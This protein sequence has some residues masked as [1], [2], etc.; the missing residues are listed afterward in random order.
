MVKPGTCTLIF[1]PGLVALSVGRDCRSRDCELVSKPD[2][3]TL[4]GIDHEIISKAILPL[5]QVQEVQ[6]SVT[7]ERMCTKCWLYCY[8]SLSLPLNSV[9]LTD[10]LNITLI[11]LTVLLN[12][13]QTNQS[14]QKNMNKKL[15]DLKKLSP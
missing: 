10:Q 4:V 1:M 6:L 5:P 13:N 12:S 11:V 15:S 3:I 14:S 2:H 7:G 8:G 9:K